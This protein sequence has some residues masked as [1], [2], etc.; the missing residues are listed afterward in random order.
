MLA[1][2][3]SYSVAHNAASISSSPILAHSTLGLAGEGAGGV[4]GRGGDEGSS[5]VRVATG[6]GITG[7]G[8]VSFSTGVGTSFTSLASNSF[9]TTISGPGP[10]EGEPD[11]G[12][13]GA[14]GV[15]SGLKTRT[16][17]RGLPVIDNA[18]EPLLPP[19]SFPADELEGLELRFRRDLGAEDL[20]DEPED[21]CAFGGARTV[22]T[23]G[24]RD[25]VGSA[26]TLLGVPC[27][28]LSPFPVLNPPRPGFDHAALDLDFVGSFFCRSR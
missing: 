9:S 12:E 7:G 20:D 15:G 13:G 17:T 18:R 26:M 11:R 27:P 25:F 1:L 28:V 22:R 6:D 23:V 19:L 5:S 14:E 4:G 2:I 10:I 24:V 3:W 8:V 16:R 21:L